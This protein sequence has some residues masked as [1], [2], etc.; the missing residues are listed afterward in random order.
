MLLNHVID[1]TVKQFVKDIVDDIKEANYHTEVDV[2]YDM[3]ENKSGTQQANRA[4]IVSKLGVVVIFPDFEK[5]SAISI[6][7]LS[8]MFSCRSA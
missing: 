2:D 1:N 6:S 4:T 3:V 7:L 5:V 8:F